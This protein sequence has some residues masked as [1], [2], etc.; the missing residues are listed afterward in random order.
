MAAYRSPSAEPQSSAA[1]VDQ[2]HAALVFEPS[3]AARDG[4]MFDAERA[5]GGR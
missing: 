5:G 2:L 3:D 1:P 4:P